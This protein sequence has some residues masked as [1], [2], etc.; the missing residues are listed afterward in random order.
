MKNAVNKFAGTIHAMALLL[1]VVVDP[2]SGL[3]AES[4]R[5]SLKPYLLDRCFVS[6]KAFG[7]DR[8]ELEQAGRIIRLC[9]ED[10]EAD[11]EKNPSFYVSKLEA[12]EK[13][14]LAAASATGKIG[15]AVFDFLRQEEGTVILDV[16]PTAEFDAGHVPQARRIGAAVEKDDPAL[17]ALDRSKPCLVYGGDGTAAEE[18]AA[19]LRKHGFAQ[20]RVLEGG[21]QAW[22][23]AGNVAVRKEIPARK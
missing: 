21:V 22:L 18:V 14:V 11:F 19:R 12:E 2:M 15:V 5:P 8:V 17:T 4:A 9:C 13:K 20:V 23:A 7:E 1:G 6:G 16:R 10:C 3:A